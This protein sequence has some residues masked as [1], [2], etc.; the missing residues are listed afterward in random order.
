MDEID[1][2]STIYYT[3]VVFIDNQRFNFYFI[4]GIVRF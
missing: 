2:Y 1:C 4:F 3:T